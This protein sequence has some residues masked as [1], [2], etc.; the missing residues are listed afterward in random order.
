MRRSK[1]TLL[2]TAIAVAAVACAAPTPTVAQTPTVAPTPTPFPT[3]TSTLAPTPTA[4]SALIPTPTPTPAPTPT[5]TPLPTATPTPTPVPT[6]TPTPE[7]AP[8]PTPTGPT[9]T[10]PPTRTPVPEPVVRGNLR[11][12]VPAGW[13]APLVANAS[14]GTQRQ[15]V[16][17]LSDPVYI[18][19]A[20]EN[21]GPETTV[22]P[23]A[24]DLYLDGVLAER[25]SGGTVS[26]GI[27]FNI[28]DWAE[29][30]QT[31]SLTP[32]THE[33][34]LVIDPFDQVSE[35]DETDNI[36]VVNV[37]VTGESAP[38]PTGRLPDLR[39]AV[40]E[41]WS[42]PLVATSYPTAVTSGPLSID[43]TTYLLYAFENA[44]PVSVLRSIPINVSIDG[45]V[46]IQDS[47]RWLRPGSVLD[48]RS[49]TGELLDKLS[50]TPGV[51][52][53]ELTID[54]GNV[55]V[56]SDE[57][58]NSYSAVFVWE[59]GPVSSEPLPPVVAAP[60]GPATTTLPN[61][62]PDWAF[63]TDRPLVLAD[64]T[65][66]ERSTS[67]APGDNLFVSPWLFNQSWVDAGP[68]QIAL[69]FDDVLFTTL[70]STGIEGGFVQFW[71]DIPVTAVPS[72]T[73]GTHTLRVVIDSANQ[74]AEQ[75]ETDN[76]FE[77][78]FDV[79][80]GSVE[81]PPSE[82][83]T[84]ADLDAKLAGLRDRLD[85]PRSVMGEGGSGET[86]A[87]LAAA[88]A[89]YF[90]AT[91]RVLADEP[92]DVVIVDTSGFHAAIDEQWLDNFAAATPEE[93]AGV[94]ASREDF[95]EGL[96]GF[97]SRVRDR[98]VVWVDAS[99]PF[100]NSLNT[101]AHE[102]GHALQDIAN[103]EQTTGE[104]SA[105]DAIREAQ[106]QVFERAFWLAV[107][108]HLGVDLTSYPDHEA[109][110]G[111]IDFVVDGW[112]ADPDESHNHGYLLAW[113][114]LLADVALDHLRVVIESERVLDLAQVKELYDHL[115][116]LGAS[117]IDE[118]V[119]A[120]QDWL[121]TA[122][123]WA[124]VLGK[125]RLDPDAGQNEGSGHT[126]VPALLMP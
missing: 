6:P 8:Q 77:L 102:L 124:R 24:I 116:G 19:W 5:P 65:G 109:F 114:A 87:L 11:P 68:H 106:A 28:V 120:R 108:G 22:E 91:G 39:A 66:S 50:L 75:D 76:T 7:P 81:A 100:A 47:W 80:P 33:L 88:E 69:Y 98:I 95:K 29:L 16:L 38:L 74:V 52:D 10:P 20:Y 107:Q 122:A 43:V 41:G 67:L 54:P 112:L 57:T 13:A 46:V 99:R 72:L 53:L 14:G 111:Q 56:E 63:G 97:K 30:P 3:P 12:Y 82:A 2:L 44:G 31:V 93:Y 27:F 45:I 126:L 71:E 59:T 49:R 60:V 64:R 23:H 48:V 35:T 83:P 9:P 42:A 61:L 89:G 85:D 26:V 73:S 37:E 118:Y 115:V 25:W 113:T 110:E 125:E 32:G 121:D 94:L 78:S 101:L 62:V 40:P 1:T 105:A 15:Q 96:A 90:L 79:P 55:I 104:G 117:T 4:T 119:D 21:D 103:P 123:D 58:N 92:I 17:R 18:S 86:A 51:H 84:T 34:R 36:F 70:D